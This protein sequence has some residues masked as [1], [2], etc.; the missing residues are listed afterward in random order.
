M[1]GN[2]HNFK[3]FVIDKKGTTTQL[4]IYKLATKIFKLKPCLRENSDS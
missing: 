3:A 1:F 4:K 2:P